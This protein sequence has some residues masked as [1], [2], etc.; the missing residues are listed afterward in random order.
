MM[1][2]TTIETI[3]DEQIMDLASEARRQGDD[4]MVHVCFVALGEREPG[5][6][7]QQWPRSQ[8]QAREECARVISDAEA[9]QD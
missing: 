1:T 2:K 3:T 6:G 8:E 5:T 9:M 4:A 7:G